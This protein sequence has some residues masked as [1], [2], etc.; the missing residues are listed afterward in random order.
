[1]AQADTIR[2]I[3]NKKSVR[4]P[5]TGR[6]GIRLVNLG[7]VLNEGEP[8]VSL[9]SLDPIFVNFSL[10]QQQLVQVE[11]FLS[12]LVTQPTRCPVRR[13]PQ[14]TTAINPQVD[15]ATRNIRVQATVDRPPRAAPAGKVRHRDRGSARQ[16]RSARHSGHLLYSM[17]LQ[18]FA[19]R[20][21]RTKKKQTTADRLG[22][23]RAPTGVRAAPE[24]DTR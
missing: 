13:L 20:R 18:R 14:C 7:Q 17:A 1:M 19:V 3:I 4:A 8:I 2:A 15:A 12:V 6:L 11:P 16:A 21:A 23:D 9:Q 22:K 24:S 5:F 10:P